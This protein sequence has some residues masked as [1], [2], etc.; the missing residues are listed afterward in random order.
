MIEFKIEEN[1]F[2]NSIY[3]QYRAKRRM[4]STQ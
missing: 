2:Y 1:M 3:N 4:S